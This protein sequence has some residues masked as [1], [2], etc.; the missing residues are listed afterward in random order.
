MNVFSFA[1]YEKIKIDADRIVPGLYQGSMP[2]QGNALREARFSVLVLAAKQYQP[3]ADRFPGVTIIH[4]PLEDSHELTKEDIG[5]A[6]TVATRV[7]VAVRNG[8]RVL[9]TC[10]EGR[11]RSGLI[12][13]LA[14]RDLYGMSGSEAMLLVRQNRKNASALT[15]TTYQQFLLSLPRKSP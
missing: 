5:S 3:K 13:A 15:N 8:S 11:N 14:L 2:P 6:M 1:P 10:L 7:A 12:T 9:V 4:V